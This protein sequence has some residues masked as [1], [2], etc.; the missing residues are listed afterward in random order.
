MVFILGTRDV[1]LHYKDGIWK[2]C[3][4]GHQMVCFGKAG[5]VVAKAGNLT[6]DRIHN[7]Q[8]RHN[9]VVKVIVLSRLLVFSPKVRDM[10]P[11][12]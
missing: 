3:F 6:S 8:N 10:V 2:L 7:F 12:S 9:H 5:V 4:G 11:I 1:G